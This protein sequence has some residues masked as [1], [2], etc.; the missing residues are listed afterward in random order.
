MVSRPVA[1]VFALLADP[2]AAARWQHG[3][4]GVRAL[5][6]GPPGLGSRLSGTR[7]YAGLRVAY[8]TEITVWDPPRRLAFRALGAPVRVSGEMALETVPDGTRVTATLDLRVGGLGLLGLTDRV[9]ERVAAELRR[10]LASLKE[11]LEGGTATA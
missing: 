7:A 8:T 9:G 2:S 6:D 5:T 1:E 11:L 10:D 3:V 4:D